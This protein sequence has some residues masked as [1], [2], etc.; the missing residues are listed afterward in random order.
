MRPSPADEIRIAQQRVLQGRKAVTRLRE[1]MANG[2]MFRNRD[3]DLLL[4]FERTLEIFERELDRLL[5]NQ[6]SN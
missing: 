1:W 2:T 4:T 5:T 3:G 6:K